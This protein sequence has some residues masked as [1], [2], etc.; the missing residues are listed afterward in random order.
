MYFNKKY[1]PN[2]ILNES[3]YFEPEF[4]NQFFPKDLEEHR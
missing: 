4:P 3:V 1:L 2:F